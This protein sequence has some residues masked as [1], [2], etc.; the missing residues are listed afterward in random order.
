[1]RTPAIIFVIL[2][3]ISL[4]HSANIGGRD[5]ED[6]DQEETTADIAAEMLTLGRSLQSGS[7]H[8]QLGRAAAVG[9]QEEAA[10]SQ[11]LPGRPDRPP[12][13]PP[14]VFFNRPSTNPVT[15]PVRKRNL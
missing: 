4:V 10:G 2:P 13:V 12:G 7:L 14:L 1:M 8:G 9:N 6:P 11:T 3:I 15:L 5:G